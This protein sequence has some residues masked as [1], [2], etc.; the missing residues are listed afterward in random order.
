MGKWIERSGRVVDATLQNIV[1]GT[2]ERCFIGDY[3]SA[4]KYY[5][6]DIEEKENVETRIEG[7]IQFQLTS[8][9]V[10]RKLSNE[11]YYYILDCCN[12]K[13]YYIEP[14]NRQDIVINAM[15]K[16]RKFMK[17]ND[18]VSLLKQKLKSRVG[19]FS[20]IERRKRRIR[21]YEEWIKTEE[22]ECIF[23]DD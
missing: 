20:A 2:N 1:L 15:K 13:K 7:I 23:C 10:V 19:N 5:G 22:Y 16:Y 21:E 18:I 6:Y 11:L 3:E 14:K 12:D 17:D 9:K 8:D 4:C